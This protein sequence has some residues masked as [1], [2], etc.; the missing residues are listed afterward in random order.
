M[1]EIDMVSVITN[2]GFSI[3]VALFLFN[4]KIVQQLQKIALIIDER[5]PK[6]V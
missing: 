2:Q 6:E 5:I 3:A 4:E 1:T